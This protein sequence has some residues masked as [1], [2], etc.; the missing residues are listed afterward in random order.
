MHLIDNMD[1]RNK[2]SYLLI[3]AGLIAFIVL[4]VLVG[5][6]TYSFAFRAAS[7]GSHF[8]DDPA[9]FV[10]RPTTEIHEGAPPPPT[11][12][13][14]GVIAPTPKGWDGA[15]RVT[16]LVMGLDY[17]DWMDDDGPS[18][19][20][21]M[22]LLTIDPL[23]KT[24]GILSIPRDLW[25]FI[26]GFDY[27]KINTAYRIGESNRIPGG[28]PGM[29]IKTVESFLGVPIDYYAQ[30]D[31]K[32]FERLIDEIGG[33]EV[34]VSEEISVDPLGPDKRVTLYPGRQMLDGP[35][36]LAYAR[37]RNTEGADFD[38]AERQHQVIF[39]IRERVLNLN[40]LPVLVSKAPTLYAELAAGME[41]NL[42]V[43][44]VV[45]LAWL[46]QQI[47]RENIK[48]GVIGPPD[49][50]RFATSPD[51]TQDILR[52]VTHMIRLLRDEIFTNDIYSPVLHN[53]DSQALMQIEGANISVL[54]GSGT[55][56]LAARTSDY[57]KNSGANILVT[58]DAGQFFNQTTIIDYTGNPYTIRYLAET[59][60]IHP[61][62][63]KIEFELDSDLDILVF[64]GA[65]WANNNSLP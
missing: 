9:A 51:G 3:G 19:T 28:G 27:G 57:L 59:M 15:T 56:G 2:Q 48:R 13:A 42:S 24:G 55:G 63:I 47:P 37:A 35:I 49:Q 32:A 25:V 65:D 26:P 45:Q 7:A 53:N 62:H 39:A 50:V 54:N 21:T 60:Q 18:R 5:A 11:P 1:T 22:I 43:E 36:A 4:T 64:L 14:P 61:S 29:A 6:V 58:G 52:P 17:R 38:R 30:V 33:I 46:A 34:D 16:I 40:M 31:F 20:D 41:T 12:D 8:L 44:Q 23:S 10:N